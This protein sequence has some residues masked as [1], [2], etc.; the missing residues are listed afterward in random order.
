MQVSH[1]STTVLKHGSTVTALPPISQTNTISETNNIK[2]ILEEIS[3]SLTLSLSLSPPPIFFLSFFKFDYIFL[4]SEF[5]QRRIGQW[6]AVMKN[7]VTHLVHR[8]FHLSWNGLNPFPDSE[9]IQPMNRRT[10]QFM[11]RWRNYLLSYSAN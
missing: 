3:H 4:T 10:N 5:M 9:E 1:T 2:A 7:Q 8:A 6:V 11:Y